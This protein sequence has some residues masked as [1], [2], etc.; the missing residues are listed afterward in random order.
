MIEREDENGTW[1]QYQKLVL[2][3][4]EQHDHRI[5][6]LQ[7]GLQKGEADRASLSSTLG[8]LK[9]DV[10]DLV[11]VIQKG[12]HPLLIRVEAI[13]GK[14]ISLQDK[15]KIRDT[16]AADKKRHEETLEIENLKHKRNM[17]IAWLAGGVA[18]IWNIV[19]FLVGK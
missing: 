6:Q 18:L 15:N 19:E 10:S 9:A 5:E 3:L 8:Q 17:L 2:K 14:I 12:P 7:S 11:D 4:L 1:A 16:D 13:E